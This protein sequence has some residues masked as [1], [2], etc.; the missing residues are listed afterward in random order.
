MEEHESEEEKDHKGFLCISGDMKLKYK[1]VNM[2]ALE[3][4][5]KLMLERLISQFFAGWNDGDFRR[6]SQ[7]NFGLL[8]AYSWIWL[9]TT[10]LFSSQ[11]HY[12]YLVTLKFIVIFN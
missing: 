1:L 8:W 4:Y 9:Q 5:P 7:L 6:L 10:T 2:L 3:N 11:Y 12:V